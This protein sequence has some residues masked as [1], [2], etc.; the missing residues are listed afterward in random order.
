MATT[1]QDKQK[2]TFKS[3]IDF[4]YNLTALIRQGFSANVTVGPYASNVQV[5]AVKPTTPAFPWKP[6]LLIGGVAVVALL[7]LKD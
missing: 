3:A 1:T 6:V 4:V 7:V 2:V 5:S